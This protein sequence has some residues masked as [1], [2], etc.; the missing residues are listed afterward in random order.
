MY[1]PEVLRYAVVKVPA[2]PP[3][4]GGRPGLRHPG[5]APL[6]C[7]AA[8]GRAP[9]LPRGRGPCRQIRTSLPARA[10]RRSRARP[11]GRDSLEYIT[12][13][14]PCQ[15]PTTKLFNCL[16]Q[17]EGRAGPS[18]RADKGE[19]PGRGR[20]PARGRCT[21][22]TEQGSERAVHP[23]P[24]PN[25]TDLGPTRAKPGGPIS[26]RKEVIQPHL[27][28]RLPCYDLVPLTPHTFGASPRVNPVRPAT[29]GADDSGDLT[30][31]V[32]KA[33]ERI[34]RRLADRRLLAIPRSRRRV[35]ACDPNWGRLCGVASASR[36]RIPLWAPIVAC[37]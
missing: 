10:A 25:R 33:R 1:Y 35:A 12:G 8:P 22:T 30:G 15:G 31:G 18:P 14:Q 21:V 20:S 7:P 11:P 29:S 6:G 13:P 24:R 5:G 17:E 26:L 37:V 36:H 28:I 27:P 4:S 3:A 23:S 16:L 34:H 19:T 2:A 9:R 32:Y